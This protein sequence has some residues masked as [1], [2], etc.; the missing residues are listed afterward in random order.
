MT[1]WHFAHGHATSLAIPRKLVPRH[2]AVVI[3]IDLAEQVDGLDNEVY[4]VDD[5]CA[6]ALYHHKHELYQRQALP[7]VFLALGIEF[8]LD[9]RN[10]AR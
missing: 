6:Q 4:L 5:E 10:I 9:F 7:L 2:G 1:R 8:V 3:H